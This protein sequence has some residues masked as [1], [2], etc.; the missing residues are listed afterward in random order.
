[1][2]KINKNREPK[3]WMKY[4]LETPDADYKSIPELR[5][6][7]LEEQGYICAYCMR[8]IPLKDRYSNEESRIEHILSQKNHPELKLV[9]TNMAICCT[10]AAN[11]KLP[12]D[13]VKTDLHCDKHKGEK[14][15]TFDLYSDSFF[16]TLTYGSRKG[17]IKSSD[18][19]YDQQINSTLNLNNKLLMANRLFALNGVVSYLNKYGW[20]TANYNKLINIWDHKDAKGYYNEYCGIVVWF[21]KQKLKQKV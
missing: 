20:T 14:D 21:L 11:T 15:I 8:R 6:S 17:N 10:G 7:L 3:E 12:C 13:K 2:R 16:T 5:K 9:Y 1:M 4:W 18:S 19:K